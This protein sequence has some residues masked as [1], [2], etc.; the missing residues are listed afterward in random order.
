[1]KTVTF[2]GSSFDQPV[3][4]MEEERQLGIA[5]GSDVINVPRKTIVTDIGQVCHLKGSQSP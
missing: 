4:N 1:M 3:T 5:I 2:Y